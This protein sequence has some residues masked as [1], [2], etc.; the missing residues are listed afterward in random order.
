M[1][2]FLVSPNPSNGNEFDQN[3]PEQRD[4]LPESI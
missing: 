2:S 1:K 4:K 3:L